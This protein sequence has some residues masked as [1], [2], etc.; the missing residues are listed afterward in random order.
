MATVVAR[1]AHPPAE[2]TRAILGLMSAAREPLSADQLHAFLNYLALPANPQPGRAPLDLR[3]GTCAIGDLHPHLDAVLARAAGFFDPPPGPLRQREDPHRFFHTRVP[4]FVHRKLGLDLRACHRALARACGRWKSWGS[5]HPAHDYA[6]RFRLGHAL[7]ARDWLLAARV[8]ADVAYIVERTTRFDFAEV[9]ADARAA[10]RLAEG[11]AGWGAAFAEWEWFLRHRLERLQRDP[12]AYAAELLNEFAPRARA[13]ALR[14][15]IE[16]AA[17][18]AAIPL[19][20]VSGPAALIGVGHTDAVTAVAFAPDGRLATGSDD[21]TAKLWSAKGQLIATYEGHRGPVLAVAFAGDGRLATGSRDRTAKLWT[22]DGRL[23]ASCAGHQGSVTAVAFA[24]DGRLA[25]GSRD[26]TTKLWA[27]DGRLIA[28]CAGHRGWVTAVAL[29]SDGR[30]ATGSHDGTAKLRTADGQLLATCAGHRG[31]VLIVAF[32][33]DGRLATG[34]RDRTAKLWAADGRLLASCEGH[35]A[36]VAAVAFAPDGR[37]ATGSR[38]RTAKLWAVDGRLLASCAGHRDRVTVLAFA[39]DGRL[40]TGSRDRTARLWSADGRSIAT[41]AGH[42]DSVIAV[43][44]ASD[45]RL[46]TG[47]RDGTAKLWSAHGRLVATCAGHRDRVTAVAFAP[48]DGWLATGSD[49]RCV[50]LWPLDPATGRPVGD[51]AVLFYDLPILA[52]AFVAGPPMR[53][54]VADSEAR[55]FVYELNAT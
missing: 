41:C 53:L 49:D 54:L 17:R 12:A 19:R 28:T 11:S 6:L 55:P 8:V 4:D 21:G 5:G 13:A 39:G 10:A 31:S 27:A 50:R 7:D 3:I 46:A 30:L 42:R 37:L 16:G 48:M 26:G 15:A 22:A 24:P 52:V 29:A 35:E 43:A 2:V 33:P 25:T 47:S 14:P 45:G 20:K 51:A 18:R 38:D 9:H 36:P 1:A 32:A 40:A 23:I 34:S 44:L